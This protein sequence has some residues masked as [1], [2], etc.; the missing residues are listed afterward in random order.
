MNEVILYLVGKMK[1]QND[2]GVGKLLLYAAFR[3]ESD[4]KKYIENYSNTYYKQKPFLCPLII[5]KIVR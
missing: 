3:A 2:L 1:I 4:A 5:K